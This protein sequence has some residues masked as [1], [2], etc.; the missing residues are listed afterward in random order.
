MSI[1]AMKSRSKS[2]SNTK[3]LKDLTHCVLTGTKFEGK[4]ENAHFVGIIDNLT[5]VVEEEFGDAE[6]SS[7]QNIQPTHKCVND[8]ME[9]GF[10]RFVK[11]DE[12]KTLSVFLTSAVVAKGVLTS[13]Y[14][15]GKIIG[16]ASKCDDKALKEI[17]GAGKTVPWPSGLVAKFVDAYNK[18][19]EKLAV[20][21]GVDE[22]KKTVKTPTSFGV[23]LKN[24]APLQVIRNFLKDFEVD[25]DIVPDETWTTDG[26]FGFNNRDKAI[27]IW[28]HV[29]DNG[30]DKAEFL[31]GGKVS[32][33]P[34]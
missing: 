18:K 26:V 25:F 4:P 32:A 13:R 11:G 17:I 21:P 16:E 7:E 31:V 30:F 12:N 14:S 8:A 23:R 6:L 5:G 19:M 15:D 10:V 27:K 20:G 3:H 1:E 2:K 24:S 28:K 34:E 29:R 9:Y 22:L 33:N